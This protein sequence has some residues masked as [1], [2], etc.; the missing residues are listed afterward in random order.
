[1]GVGVLKKIITGGFLLLSGVVLYVGIKIAAAMAMPM[2][3]GWS[4]STGRFGAAVAEVDGGFALVI[5]VLL[6]IVGCVFIISE[7]L[8][9]KKKDENIHE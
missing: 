1:M 7:S 2:V 6:G 8:S 5:S 9:S 4:K 3:N